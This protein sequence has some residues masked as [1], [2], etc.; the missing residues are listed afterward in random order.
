MITD[1]LEAL[2]LSLEG[3]Y[4]NRLDRNTT[5]ALIAELM[6]LRQAKTQWESRL[7]EDRVQE[8]TRENAALIAVRDAVKEWGKAQV[9]SHSQ[10]CNACH[11]CEV[12]STL[13]TLAA[14]LAAEGRSNE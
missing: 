6:E 7:A 5:L 10:G 9:M 14:K 4:L 11:V 3:H 2:K 1:D 8:L 13:L 12:E